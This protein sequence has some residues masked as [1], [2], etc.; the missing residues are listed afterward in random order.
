[1]TKKQTIKMHETEMVQ[2]S[3]LRPA[4]YN[5]RVM[6]DA[7]MRSLMASLRESGLVLNLVVQRKSP[8][9]GSMVIVGGHQRV[10]ALRRICG[11]DGTTLPERVPAVVLDLSDNEAK[12]LNVALNR[13]EGEFVDDMLGDLLASL[14]D[15][16][17]PAMTTMGL[18]EDEYRGLV[19]A[20]AAP[21]LNMQAD[22]LEMEAAALLQSAGASGCSLI[23]EFDDAESRDAARDALRS[24]A[25]GQKVRPGKVL[26]AALEEAGLLSKKRVVAQGI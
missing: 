2:F 10:E 26:L 5:P 9:H 14:G 22:A 23:V 8:E 15:I 16:D 19:E 1:M 24:A 3:K 18:T 11:E 21:D 4:P 20:S 7:M 25:K 13:V 17:L 6:P 12:R